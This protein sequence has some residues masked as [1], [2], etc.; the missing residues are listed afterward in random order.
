ME[1][2]SNASRMGSFHGADSEFSQMKNEMEWNE[3]WVELIIWNWNVKQNDPWNFLKTHA[4]RMSR[5]KLGAHVCACTLHFKNPSK[6][7]NLKGQIKQTASLAQLYIRN[8]YIHTCAR[9]RVHTHTCTHTD[10]LKI[11]L[12]YK[13]WGPHWCYRVH[14]LHTCLH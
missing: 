5:G 2:A 13:Q 10:T 7:E 12:I 6:V 9:A 14:E 3:T 11:I 4:P 8:S 1:Y